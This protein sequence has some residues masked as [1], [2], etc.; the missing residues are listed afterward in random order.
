MKIAFSKYEGTG[1]DFIIINGLLHPGF[2]PNRTQIKKLCDR[3]FGIGADGLIILKEHKQLDF[4][5]EYF[6]ADGSKS[7]C[8][9]GSRCGVHFASREQ[10]FRSNTCTFEAIDGEHFAEINNNTIKLKMADVETIEKRKDA[11]LV[12]TGSPHYLLESKNLSKDNIVDF[13]RKIRYLEEFQN[14][15]IN[16][17]L[18]EVINASTAKLLTYERGVENETLSCGTGATACGLVMHAM[19]PEINRAQIQAKGGNLEVCFS[20]NSEKKEYQEIFLIGMVNFVYN[21]EIYI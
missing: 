9:N 17:N 12:D 13:G 18:F 14:E 16:V 20:F 5:L 7:F 21:G 4:Y 11:F 3:K 10:F 6:N 1:N 15:G 8:G 2:D 19:H